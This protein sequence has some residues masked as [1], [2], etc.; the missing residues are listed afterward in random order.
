[1]CRDRGVRGVLVI[2]RARGVCRVLVVCSCSWC[3]WCAR[4]LL[5]MCSWFDRG[6]RDLLV[7]CVRD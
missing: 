3:V 2:V 7:V 6:V 1:M 5:V 4:Y